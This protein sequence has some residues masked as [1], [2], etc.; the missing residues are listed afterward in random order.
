MI[1]PSFAEHH[2]QAEGQGKGQEG[3]A[4]FKGRGWQDEGR[5][6]QAAQALQLTVSH[7]LT[8]DAAEKVQ[9]D[10]IIEAVV[11]LSTMSPNKLHGAHLVLQLLKE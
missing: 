8:A 11:C 9:A 2:F 3:E 1:G 10:S 7:F 5:I 6:Q 4:G